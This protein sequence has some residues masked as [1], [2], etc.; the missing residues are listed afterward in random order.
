MLTDWL[1]WLDYLEEN[2]Y[3]TT[4]LRLITPIIFGII[5]TDCYNYID[6]FGNGFGSGLSYG[7]DS[8]NGSGN[9]SGYGYGFGSGFGDERREEEESKD[10]E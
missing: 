5:E 8:G 3:N 9:G 6:D 7:Y 10:D 2:N 1:I 4:F